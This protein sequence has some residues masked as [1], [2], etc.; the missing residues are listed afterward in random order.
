MS[1]K[2]K[3]AAKTN[4]VPDNRLRLHQMDAFHALCEVDNI[5]TAQNIPFF[6]V[7]G[8]ALGAVRHKGFIPWDDD[9]DIGIFY[10]D[11]KAAYSALRRNL[12]APYTWK[13]RFSDRT[14]PRLYGKILSD[15]KPLIDVFV[16]VKTS[17]SCV[18]R[19]RQWL[20]RKILFKLY[21][22]KIGYHNQNEMK[23]RFAV[24]KV[25]LVR[26]LSRF[27]SR[28]WIEKQIRKNESR[29]EECRDNRYYLNLYSIYSLKKELIRSEWV[30]SLP[31]VQF[32]TS[33][34]PTLCDTHA[35]LTHLYG[36]YMR[37]PDKKHRSPR[38]VETF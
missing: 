37:I 15:G 21:K 38:H 33:Q 11:M 5:L 29:Y 12:P 34:F 10:K 14:Y 3:T 24:I 20:S 13:D 19:L 18:G 7:A 22:G 30:R 2:K 6:L 9:I 36:D 25:H 17:D 32:E 35:Y 26:F 8:S 31:R 1:D 28:K 23:S 4:T 16:I 27:V